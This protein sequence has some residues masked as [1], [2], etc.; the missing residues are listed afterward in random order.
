MQ[1]FEAAVQDNVLVNGR[2]WEE[3]PDVEG[4]SP[5]LCNLFEEFK[6]DI[7]KIKPI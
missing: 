1:N 6:G 4:E 7:T 3:A 2:P 5:S